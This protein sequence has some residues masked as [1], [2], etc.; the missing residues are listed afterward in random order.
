MAYHLRPGYGLSALE[1][2]I[3]GL[4][5]RRRRLRKNEIGANEY[6][7]SVILNSLNK[8]AKLLYFAWLRFGTLNNLLSRS[9]IIFKLCQS[10]YVYVKNFLRR[11]Y[12]DTHADIAFP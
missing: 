4:T 1:C 7:I 6:K 9:N 3:L 2:G 10:V 8:K 5:G 12:L 11:V